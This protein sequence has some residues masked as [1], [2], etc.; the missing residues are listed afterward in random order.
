[1]C[2]ALALNEC[3][4]SFFKK[5]KKNLFFSYVIMVNFTYKNSYLIAH[6]S[7]SQLQKDSHRHCNLCTHT[8]H[9]DV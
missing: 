4:N 1:M 7:D 3:I 2:F 9:H 8:K 5:E 6:Y